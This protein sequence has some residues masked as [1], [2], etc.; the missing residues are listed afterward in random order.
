MRAQSGE[1][2]VIWKKHVR[3][4]GKKR[5]LSTQKRIIPSKE[6][7]PECGRTRR[8][9]IIMALLCITP[10]SLLRVLMAH[11]P[12]VAFIQQKVPLWL[13]RPTPQAFA[14]RAPAARAAAASSEWCGELTRAT[15]GEK[16]VQRR[17][18]DQGPGSPLKQ[19]RC[20]RKTPVGFGN[21]RQGG[22][23]Q[24][25]HPAVARWPSPFRVASP[26]PERAWVGRR[27]ASL[28]S[29]RRTRKTG[30]R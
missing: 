21:D 28:T 26:G 17:P 3:R 7:P 6:R 9:F 2:G 5:R 22:L 23:R 4:E 1:R 25:P 10:S 8:H 18:A 19:W 20:T 15:G 29:P 30:Q 16:P 14:G 27:G 12:P 13:M 24:R 11:G